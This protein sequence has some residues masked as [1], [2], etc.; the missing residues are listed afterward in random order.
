MVVEDSGPGINQTQ[1]DSIFN[2]FV[3]TKSNGMGLGLAICRQIVERH[4]GGLFACS[5]SSS[6]AQFEVVLP[7]RWTE[8]VSDGA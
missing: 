1:L 7:M 6:G 4:G 2:A 3:T 5:G 8:D